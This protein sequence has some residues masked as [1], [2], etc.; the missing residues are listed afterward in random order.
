MKFNKDAVQKELDLA[1]HELEKAGHKDLAERV[2]YYGDR[3]MKVTAGEVPLLRRALSRVLDEA[4]RRMQGAKQQPSAAAT[5][6]HHAVARS[7]R[8]SDPRK[9][10]LK[11]KLMEIAAKRKQAARRLESLRARREARSEDPADSRRSRR[12]ERLERD[13]R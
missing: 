13:S 9:E 10:A 1:A 11:R 3:L 12:Q 8:A 5:K 4:K 2:D 7:R 6:A